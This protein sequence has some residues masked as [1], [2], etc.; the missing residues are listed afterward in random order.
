[1]LILK[2]LHHDQNLKKD[3]DDIKKIWIKQKKEWQKNI[4]DRGD[5]GNTW[6]N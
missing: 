4:E 6:W 3:Q 2:I 1:V 5:N